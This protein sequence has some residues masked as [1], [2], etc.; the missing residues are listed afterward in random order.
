MMRVRNRFRQRERN[1]SSVH[2]P[3][4]IGAPLPV[5]SFIVMVWL[6]RNTLPWPE[7]QQPSE[8]PAENN[9]DVHVLSVA[10]ASPAFRDPTSAPIQDFSGKENLKT[11]QF[12]SEKITDHLRRSKFKNYSAF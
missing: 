12:V 6:F 3:F 11:I 5:F 4:H 10:A 8:A 7:F 9:G 1:V 2:V